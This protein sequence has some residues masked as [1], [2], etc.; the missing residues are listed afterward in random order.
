MKTNIDII[1]KCNLSEIKKLGNINYELG[2]Y[3]AVISKDG[4]KNIIKYFISQGACNYNTAAIIA[5]EKGNFENVKYLIDK[6]NISNDVII[7]C[8]EKYLEET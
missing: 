4:I 5:A 1:K 7:Q 3:H 6:C 2:L 8:F